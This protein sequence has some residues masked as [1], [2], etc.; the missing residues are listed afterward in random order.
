MHTV[1][2]REERAYPFVHVDVF[3]D[4][5]FGG[6]YL[7]VFPD[8]EGLSAAEM[9]SIA[10]EMNLS[11]TVFVL[12]PSRPDCAASLRIFTPT[13][14]L[15]FAGHPTIGTSWVLA[16]VG[17]VPKGLRTFQLEEGVGPIS[18]TID[19]GAAIWMKHPSASFG[20][21]ILD[22][23]G[24]A[25]A[26]G[27]AESDLLEGAPIV[28]GSTGVPFLYVP[29]RDRSIVDSAAL[30]VPALERCGVEPSAQGVFVFAPD[31][32]GARVYSR[33]FAPHTLGI[34]E[35]PAT[36]GAS[37]PLG[38][39]LVRNALIPGEGDVALVSEQGTKM[40]RQSFVHIR[41]QVSNREATGIEIGGTVVPVLEGV[42]RL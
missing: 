7:A 20:P 18:I 10:G 23:H 11:E 14:E 17:V 39:Y 31:A 33:M 34:A 30:D 13:A 6:N 38:A 42:L 32:N 40:G 1:Q 3:T 29:L 9:Q 25:L 27:L 8:A 2:V 24:V 28:V 22:R 16:S 4:H 35:D 5:M 15:P 19:D 41:M 37:G 26:L 12:P 36:G 21:P